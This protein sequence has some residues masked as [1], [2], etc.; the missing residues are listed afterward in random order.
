MQLHEV[1]QKLAT[2]RLYLCGFVWRVDLI[3]VLDRCWCS[4]LAV[5]IGSGCSAALWHERNHNCWN[6]H[7]LSDSRAFVKVT[8]TTSSISQASMR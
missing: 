8:M 2:G 1:V 7:Q 6:M 5:P 3:L 4:D